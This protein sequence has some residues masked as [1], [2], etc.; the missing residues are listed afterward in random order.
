MTETMLPMTKNSEQSSETSALPEAQP[1]L[2]KKQEK[3]LIDF[4]KKS[5]QNAKTDRWRDE[6]QWYINLAFYFGKQNIYVHDAPGT[7]RQFKLYTP[8]APYYR[9]RPI[10]NRCRP[11]VRT[12]M[13]KLTAQ[14]PSAF[15]VPASSDERDLFASNAGEQLWD[16]M[17]R[18]L[19]IEAVNRTAVFW[20]TVTGNGFIKEY[21]DEYKE[22]YSNDTMGA[23]CVESVTPFHI[24]V[25]DLTEVDIERQAWVIHAANK[26]I[27]ELELAYGVQLK[28]SK[29][30]AGEILEE[31]FTTAM[32]VNKDA[33]KQESTLVLE[34]WIKPGM[35]AKY[36][37]GGVYTIAGDQVLSFEVGWPYEHKRYPFAHIRHIETGKFYTESTLVDLIPLQREYNRTRGQIIEAKNRMSKP[38]LAA[39]IGSL[40]P[41]KITSEPGQVIMYRPGFSAPQPIVLQNLPSYVL[42][43]LDRIQMDMNEISGQHEVSRGGVPPGVTAA[44]AISYL[45]EQDDT[46]LSYS[47]ASIEKCMEKIAY[48]TLC[49][50]KQ[51]WDTPR[52][53]KVTGADGSFDVMAFEGSDLR[54]NTDVHVEGGSSLPTSRAAKQAFILD[55]MKLGFIDPTKGLEVMEIGGINKV[56][57]SIQTDT[58]QA[59]RENLKLAQV[60]EEMQMQ[61][62]QE[63][64]Q[65]LMEDPQAQQLMEA[66]EL[67]LD[68]E[69]GELSAGGVPFEMPMIVPVNDWDNHQVH[70]EKHNDYRKSQ[71]YEALP[72]AAKDAFA[73]HVNQHVHA[74]MMGAQGAMGIPP[75][76][77]AMA[78]NPESYQY[79]ANGGDT[80]P[81]PGQEQMG[82]ESQTQVPEQTSPSGSE[83]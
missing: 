14:K 42:Q 60:T 4:V 34:M 70:I 72:Q 7:S 24:F 79:M 21:W 26:P 22:D 62:Q 27:E 41:S 32:G 45:Q 68:P 57:E 54:D 39:E 43:E 25:P 77:M 55:L 40:D 15:I 10:I 20:S 28:N 61:H 29:T 75:E 46:K 44:T 63:T 53:V 33:K 11:L 31:S 23:I 13:A 82:P 9:S 56:Y 3:A 76:A 80:T 38:Q 83:I 6:R 5:Y 81:V 12:E 2:S 51:Y 67:I 49:Y 37:E 59:Q 78:D 16:S 52:M 71:A 73:D 48:M 74:I 35:C 36:P 65:K 50:I 58:R 47:Y 19:D 69:T 17:Y 64:M 8:P 66:G 30:S 18:E 1:L